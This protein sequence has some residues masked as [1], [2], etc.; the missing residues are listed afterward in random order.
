MY[1]RIPEVHNAKNKYQNEITEK[2][3]KLQAEVVFSWGL[4]ADPNL[5]FPAREVHLLWPR[6]AAPSPLFVTS[7]HTSNTAR[8]GAVEPLVVRRPWLAASTY[9]AASLPQAGQQRKREEKE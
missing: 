4:R 5:Q 7:R 1:S 6:P 3:L 8:L 2:K 9:P